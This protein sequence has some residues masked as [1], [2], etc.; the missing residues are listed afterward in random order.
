MAARINPNPAAAMTPA[1]VKRLTAVHGWAG[2]VL[3]LV[4]YVVVVT[5][6]VVVFGHDL[7]AWSQGNT[8]GHLSLSHVGLID[9]FV[10]DITE[11]TP[12]ANLGTVN[13]YG[14]E[15]GELT[16]ATFTRAMHAPS[17]RKQA[18]GSIYQMDPDTGRLRTREDGF[19][20]VE[21]KKHEASAL[22][23][24]LVEL[25]IRLF[26]P[27]PWG[28]ILTGVMG[29]LVMVTGITGFLMHR[30]LIHDL[31]V[32]ARPGERLVTARDRHIL[33]ATWSLVFAFLL[34]FTGSFFSFAGTLTFPL[35]T[36]TA[37]GGDRAEMQRTLFTPKVTPDPRPADV[38]DLDT[39]IARSTEMAGSPLRFMR[40]RNWG[41]ADATIDIFHWPPRDRLARIHHVF[42]GAD[43]RFLLSRPRIGHQPSLGSDLYDLIQPLH[44]GDFA[45]VL[46]KSVWVGLGA[47][48]AYVIISGLQLWVRRRDA[49]PLW[50]GFG[51]AVTIT[52]Y[53]LPLA[54]LASAYAFFLA[55]ALD[56][57]FE[58]TSKGFFIGCA[59]AI[60][61]GAVT[62]QRRLASRYRT[63]LA[64]ACM[65]LPVLR[66]VLG[67]TGWAA[68]ITAGDGTIIGF[69]LAL[70][71][72]GAGVWF[73]RHGPG[74]RKVAEMKT[75][76]AG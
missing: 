24:F 61:F 27:D 7:A 13:V 36:Q 39:V 12:K 14:S 8:R 62:D 68:A 60:L 47:A 54:V 46:S 43:G 34:G 35:V 48:M 30:H 75:S 49:D 40:I 56:D 76:E 3:G 59:G 58:W 42:S 69:D 63:V 1:Q 37:F 53:G 52:G 32:A 16:V 41:R 50:R 19:I 26:V 33:A 4:L 55:E 28:S 22:E 2:V 71:V 57:P 73:R 70:I 20:Y 66:L 51:R 31:F 23:D 18:F 11:R 29:L 9:R 67:G 38:V 17:G 44:F 25:H 15:R 10:R 72:L 45:G 74:V 21:P 6:T 5:G 64:L 65:G